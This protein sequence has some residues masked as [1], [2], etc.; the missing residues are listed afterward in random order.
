MMNILTFD[1]WFHSG[2][3]MPQY[4]LMLLLLFI[5]LMAV[6]I[7]F[8]F[9]S[10]LNNKA[11]DGYTRNLYRKLMDMLVTMGGIGIILTFFYYEGA[12]IMSA[13]FWLGV[14]LIALLGWLIPIIKYYRSIAAKRDQR[15]KMKKF[16]KYLP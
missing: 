13:K 4:A 3:I 16:K 11:I 2:A 12:Y 15:Q 8:G 1:F 5:I 7:G 6:G 14:W 10:S 9:K